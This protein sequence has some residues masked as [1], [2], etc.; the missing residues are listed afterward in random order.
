MC[1]HKR[2]SEIVNPTVKAPY[3]QTGVFGRNTE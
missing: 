2:T 3:I 1:G